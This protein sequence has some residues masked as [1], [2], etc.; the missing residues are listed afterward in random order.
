MQERRKS[1]LACQ[2][3]VA[4]L[5]GVGVAGAGCYTLAA[6]KTVERA[7]QAGTKVFHPVRGFPLCI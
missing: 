6:G 7:Q 5:K 1:K 2:G 3:A 4:A